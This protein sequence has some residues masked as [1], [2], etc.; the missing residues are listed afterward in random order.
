MNAKSSASPNSDAFIFVHGFNNNFNDA[1]LRTAQFT[2][3]VGFRGAPL[4]F[5][6]PSQALPDY[7]GYRAD[8]RINA[9]SVAPFKAFMT[10]YLQSS[11]ATNIYLIAHSMGNRIMMATLQQLMQEKPALFTNRHVREIV[12]TAP[13]I[14]VIDFKQK[15]APVL[16]GKLNVTLYASDD[17][18]ALKASYLIHG[19]EPRAGQAGESGQGLLLLPGVETIDATGV[20][21][22]FLGHS[23]FASEASVMSDLR[24]LLLDKKRAA[25]RNELEQP[26]A[27]RYWRFRRPLKKDI[28][29]ANGDR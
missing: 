5:S 21:T 14:S 16:R 6:W 26:A 27:R 17:D 28:T 2:Y 11:T 25:Q 13:D 18:N 12:L 8:E 10:S 24:Y 7:F 1:L 19:I 3:D 20:S 15:I 22:D 4:L 29:P 23:Y 9:A